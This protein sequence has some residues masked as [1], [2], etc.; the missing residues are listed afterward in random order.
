VD[1]HPCQAV[2]VKMQQKPTQSDA[3]LGGSGFTARRFLGKNPETLKNNVKM[4]LFTCNTLYMNQ[5]HKV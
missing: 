5:T 1:I 2:H 3:S 4:T